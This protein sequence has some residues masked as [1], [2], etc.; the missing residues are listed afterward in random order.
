M[1]NR[2]EKRAEIEKC[3]KFLRGRIDLLEINE[4]EDYRPSS[5]NEDDKEVFIH[6]HGMR[7]GLRGGRNI[8]SQ[9]Y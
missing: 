2:N 9:L 7:N 6:K 3:V 5:S 8:R 1:K 4:I